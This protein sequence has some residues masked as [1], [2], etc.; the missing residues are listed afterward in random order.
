MRFPALFK[1][2]LMALR[3]CPTSSVSIRSLESPPVSKARTPL[4]LIDKNQS[5][6]E[7]NGIRERTEETDGNDSCKNHFRAVVTSDSH[8]EL[9]EQESIVA[10]TIFESLISLGA[11]GCNGG[12]KDTYSLR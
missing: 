4:T 8:L 11:P 9:N 12:G 7:L 10:D 6:S 2:A 3:D 1:L 5:R